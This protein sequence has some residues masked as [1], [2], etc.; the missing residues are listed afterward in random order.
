MCTVNVASFAKA[1]RDSEQT[2]QK[3]AVMYSMSQ[4]HHPR[5]PEIERFRNKMSRKRW[6][7]VRSDLFELL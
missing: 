3:M 4:T 6:I 1:D 7:S 5:I 2:I